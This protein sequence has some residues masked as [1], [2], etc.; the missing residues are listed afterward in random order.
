MTR[1]S[2][3]AFVTAGAILLGPLAFGAPRPADPPP[4]SDDTRAAMAAIAG[5]G[6]MN[7]DA[8]RLLEDLSH[9][10]GPRV[11]AT[12]SC[13]RAIQWGLATMNAIGLQNGE[14]GALLAKAREAGAV[15]VIG[16]QGGAKAQGMHLTHTGAL[17]FDTS[18]AIPVVS[19]SAEDQDI[20]ERFLDRGRTPRIHID[21]QN[22]F[23]DGPADTANVVGEI[24]GTEHP[25]QVIV[26]GGHLDSW[27]LAEGSTDDGVG[28]ATTLG[29]AE[30][31]LRSG[32]RPK[33][34]I[35]FVLFT[36]EEQGLL[37]SLAYVKRHKADMVN[38]VAAVILDNGQGPVTALNMGGRDD[39]LEAVAP[40]TSALAAFWIA[41]RPE[42]LASPWPAERSAKMLVDKHQDRILEMYGIWPFGDVGQPKP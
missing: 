32:R 39:L 42:R 25:E 38:H 20:L 24:P 1:T 30:A 4:A 34:T 16:G 15:A 41:D 3:A 5:Q 18:Y 26:V 23:T 6:M 7:L 37:G 13:N 36:G 19:M 21:V 8:Y 9:D 2:L 40:L 10:I 27:D 22:R 29:A 28:V 33:R 14:F 12:P 17:G 11:T 35:R 31:I